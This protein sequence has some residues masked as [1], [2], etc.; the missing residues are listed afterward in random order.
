[1]QLNGLKTRELGRNFTYLESVNSTNTWLAQQADTLPHG[2]AVSAAR[3][4]AGKGRRGR[5]WADN[6]GVGLALSVLVDWDALQNPQLPLLVGLAACRAIEKLC[7]VSAQL[8]WSNDLLL[9]GKKIGGILCESPP[10]KQKR[11]VIGVGVNLA[12]TQQHFNDLGLVYAT[13]L[14]LGTKTVYSPAQM[15]VF[16][17]NSLEEVLDEFRE[18]GFEAQR[19]EY[20]RRCVVL[21]REIRIIAADEEYT[22]AA[23]DIAPDGGLICNVNGKLR[24]FYAGD[25]SIRG[26]EGY[27]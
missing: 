9:N 7:G 12:Q 13:S 26:A 18:K 4:T 23:L 3:Q 10:A 1:M 20:A 19:R 22:G 17:L 2:A 27:I 14:L 16:L 21:G 24:T 8:K 6:E 15:A 11:A 25:V 5:S